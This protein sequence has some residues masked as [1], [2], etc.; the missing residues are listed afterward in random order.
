MLSVRVYNIA[1][2]L[3]RFVKEASVLPGLTEWA[4]DGK[5]DGGGRVGNGV[6]FVQVVTGDN[7]QIKKV[8]VLK[9]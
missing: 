1:G 3:V 8:I 7:V 2:E 4:W 5:N 6:Y 9:K